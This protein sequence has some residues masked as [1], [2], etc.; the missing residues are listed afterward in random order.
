MIATFINAAAVIVGSLIGLLIRKGIKEEYRKVVFTA[1][2]LTS[3]TIGIQMALKTSHILSF[4]LAL[5]IGGLLGTLLDVEGGIERFGERLK[6][7]FASKSEGAFAAGFLNASI[8]FCAG[9]MAIVGSFRAGTEGNYSLIFTKSVL[10]GFVS[11]IFAGAMGI[12]VAFS[13]LSILVYQGALTLLSVY[14]KPYVSDLMLAEITG[15]G[16]ALVIMIGFGL[17]EIKSFK[18]GNFLPALIIIVVLVLVMPVLK[19]L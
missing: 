13:A 12:G 3:L 15:I 19:F 4:A 17:L 14:I 6:Q 10:D 8:L 7:R 2:G 18:T 11:I 9:A 5:M 1:A 16:G